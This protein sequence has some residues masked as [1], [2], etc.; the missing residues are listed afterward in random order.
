ML[1]GGE[2]KSNIV[3]RLELEPAPFNEHNHTWG[4]ISWN[5]LKSFLSWC[6][7]TSSLLLFH[8]LLH[9]LLSFLVLHK[10]LFLLLLHHLFPL[11]WLL[12]HHN[13]FLCWPL[14]LALLWCLLENIEKNVIRKNLSCFIGKIPITFCM[15][16]K[17]SSVEKVKKWSSSL[18][19]SNLSTWMWREATE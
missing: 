3:F 14:F 6:C 11:L 4:M 5:C 10:L 17:W 7:C 15:C 8:V 9:K 19:V 16:T 13:I 2:A 1:R 12:H 18:K